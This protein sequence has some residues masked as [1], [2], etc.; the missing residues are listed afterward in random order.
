MTTTQQI[1][2]FIE[3]QRQQSKSF[4]VATV[5]NISG[6]TA[7]VVGTKAVITEDGE[8]HGF[9]GGG[10]VMGAVKRNALECLESGKPKLIRVAPKD[11]QN[12]NDELGDMQLFVSHCAS[13]GTADFFLEPISAKQRLFIC[14]SSPIAQSLLNCAQNLGQSVSVIAAQVDQAK[15]IGADQYYEDYNFDQWQLTTNDSVIIATQGKQDQKALLAAL[16]SSA[17]YKAMICSAK[18]LVNLKQKILA[19]TDG[20]E[21]LFANLYAPAGLN[22]G[23][24]TPEEIALAIISEMVAHYRKT[25]GDAA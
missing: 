12:L 6:S 15:I 7:A 10:C 13:G 22:I 24:I 3:Q 9:I 1:L 25:T 4:C 14:G 23:A 21:A 16:N 19:E 20:N 18:K 2:D 5:I 17:G 11:K 8:L